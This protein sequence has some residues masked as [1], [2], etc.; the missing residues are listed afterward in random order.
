[1][2]DRPPIVRRIDHVGVAVHDITASLGYYVD[3]LGMA[4]SV[5]TLLADGSARLAYLEAGETTLQLVQPLIPGPVAEFLTTYGEGLHH[6][7][8]T[9][10]D[11]EQALDALPSQESQDGIYVGG[12]LCRVSFIRARPNGV[13]IELTEP[14]PLPIERVSDANLG[15]VS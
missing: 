14:S 1:M 5:D 2:T 7:C 11:L 12:R 3:V 8:F 6:V 9:V 15:A 13:V 10:D 4:V